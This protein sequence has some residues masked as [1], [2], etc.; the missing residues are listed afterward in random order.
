[1]KVDIVDY[2]ENPEDTMAKAARNDYSDQYIGG[3]AFEE[4]MDPVDYEEDDLEWVKSELD[5][6]DHDYETEAKKKSFIEG[7]LS[8]EHYGPAEHAL[9]VVSIEGVS[10]SL[11]AQFTRHR[12]MSFDVQSMRYVDFEDADPIVPETLRDDSQHLS[13]EE[14][15]VDLDQDV[16]DKHRERY[17]ELMDELTDFYSDA[18]EDGVPKEDARFA[19]PLGTPVN[20][21]ASGNLRSWMHVLNVRQKAD[22]QWEIRELS[23][24]ITE[25]LEDVAPITVNYFEE[26]GPFKLGL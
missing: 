9:A 19:M 26:N 25:E 20:M 16:R 2:T 1:V 5:D 12:H 4:I 17:E 18:V 21:V 7:L 6:P 22:A 24:K 11:M 23:N 8:R 13:R 10:R 15:L 3:L 14:G